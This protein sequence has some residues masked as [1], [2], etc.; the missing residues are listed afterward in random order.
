M[1]SQSSRISDIRYNAADRA[2]EAVVTLY[3]HGEAFSFPI[4]LRAPLDTDYSRVAEA[5]TTMAQRRLDRGDTRL[6]ATRRPDSSALG[7]I[8]MA[9][10]SATNS[11]WDRL[12]G[13]AA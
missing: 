10:H 4:S 6:R 12:L 2:F 5:M 13:R 1:S 3:R 7:N 8:P 11:L 9:V